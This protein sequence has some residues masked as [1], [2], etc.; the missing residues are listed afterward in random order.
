MDA[1]PTALGFGGSRD[2]R[3]CGSWRGV[4]IYFGGFA[5]A[6]FGFEV[7]VVAGEAAE[8]GYQTVGKEGDVGVVVLN[9]FVVAAALDGDAVLRA[10][11]FVL[12]AEEILVGL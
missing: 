1:R 12:E 7:G 8:A 6:G 5:G 10:G 4:E 11:Q 2:G 3:G 9:G